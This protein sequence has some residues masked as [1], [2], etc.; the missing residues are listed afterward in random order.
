[1]HGFVCIY[2]TWYQSIKHFQPYKAW[3]LWLAHDSA[4]HIRSCFAIR[5]NFNRLFGPIFGTETNT[6][7]IFGT[8]SAMTEL[9]HRNGVCWRSFLRLTAYPLLTARFNVKKVLVRFTTPW[10]LQSHSCVDNLPLS[11]KKTESVDTSLFMI[12]AY[13]QP[14][15][16]FRPATRRDSTRPNKINEPRSLECGHRWSLE[17]R[18]SLEKLP[19]QIW[20]F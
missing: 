13:L 7:R 12:G 19:C 5:P 11:Q 10:K 1:V 15:Q 9:S 6:K 17:T 18:R 8:G 16:K 2:F 14:R 20:S 4:I 3:T